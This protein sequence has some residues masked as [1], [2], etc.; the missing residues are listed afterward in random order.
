ME[1]ASVQA[2]DDSFKNYVRIYKIDTQNAT[3][4]KNLK[5]I[6]NS[7]IKPVKKQLIANL[8]SKDIAHIDNIEGMSFGKKL[9]NGHDSLVIASDDNFNKAQKSQFLAF[10]VIPES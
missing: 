8:N 10:E 1:R 3:D 6:K 2:A 7:N 4:I 9:P 5:S